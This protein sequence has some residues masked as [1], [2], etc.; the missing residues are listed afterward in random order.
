MPLLLASG[1]FILNLMV[2]VSYFPLDGVQV[3][4]FDFG[5]K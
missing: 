3:K 1:S 4:K 5:N 2:F